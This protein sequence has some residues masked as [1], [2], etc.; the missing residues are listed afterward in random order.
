[1]AWGK[2]VAIKKFKPKDVVLLKN[3]YGESKLK[4]IVVEVFKD[5]LG[6]W[7]IM[8]PYKKDYYLKCVPEELILIGR[9]NKQWNI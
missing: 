5:I 7:V 8:S 9:G 1:M 6:H 3:P 4:G 2:C